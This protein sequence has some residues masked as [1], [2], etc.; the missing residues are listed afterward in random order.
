M[1]LLSYVVLIL[2]PLKWSLLKR[3]FL[4]RQ[5]IFSN[6]RWLRC[7]HLS[8]CYT[9]IFVTRCYVFISLYIMI[10]LPFKW[11]PLNRHFSLKQTL[12]SDTRRPWCQNPYICYARSLLLLGVSI[13]FP[14]KC[15]KITWKS[16]I[17]CIDVVSFK[18]WETSKSMIICRCCL[19]YDG[20]AARVH[21]DGKTPPR[22]FPFLDIASLLLLPVPE[23]MTQ[24]TLTSHIPLTSLL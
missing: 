23:I 3:H 14:S 6:S 22:L 13:F 16:L 4:L 11:S 17:R 19:T 1:D 12:F 24:G 2:F 18:K 21:G 5:K 10:L 7:H 15:E 9:W 20:T 8:I